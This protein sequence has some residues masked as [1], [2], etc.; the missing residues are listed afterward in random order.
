[1]MVPI[2]SR[3]RLESLAIDQFLLPLTYEEGV[4][5]VSFALAFLGVRVVRGSS[6]YHRAG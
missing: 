4:S 3:C 2:R 1:M 6:A 5:S